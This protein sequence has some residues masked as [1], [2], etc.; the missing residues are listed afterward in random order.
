MKKLAVA[1]GITMSLVTNQMVMAKEKKSKSPSKRA[2]A[3]ASV[4]KGWIK[5]ITKNT[6]EMEKLIEKVKAL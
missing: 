1:I 5:A 3:Q 6:Y 4:F 2:P